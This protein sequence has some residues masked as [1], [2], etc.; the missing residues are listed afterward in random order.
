MKFDDA[1]FVINL[2]V[3]A[4][5]AVSTN[6]VLAAG[7]AGAARLVKIGRDAFIS[8][9][10]R[11]EWTPEQVE[12]FDKVVHPQIASQAHWMKQGDLPASASEQTP[13]ML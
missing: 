12:H 6:P 5:S 8:G 10:D 7:A 13:E 1:M 3:S 4:L 11:G 2:G 9:R